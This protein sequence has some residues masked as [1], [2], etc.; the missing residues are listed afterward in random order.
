MSWYWEDMEVGMSDRFGPIHVE[1]EEVL[2]FARRYDPQ[3]FHLDDEAAAR[4]HFGRL[5]ASG[6][7]TCSMMMAAMVARWQEVPGWQ[8]QSLGAM[9]IDELRWRRPVFPGDTLRGTSELIAKVETRS[10]REMG[11]LK[12][13]T[14]LFNQD[15]A[16]VL[17]LISIVMQRRRPAGA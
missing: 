9:G 8:E 5:A 13:H 2:A 16:E 15:D 7:H 17:S 3:P 1:R 4:T 14:R 11:I 10:R 6:W 12:W